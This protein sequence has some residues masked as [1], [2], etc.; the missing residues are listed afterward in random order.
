MSQA[1]AA[2]PQSPVQELKAPA[3]LMRADLVPG[4][5][6]DY[7]DADGQIRTG[8]VVS[9]TNEC[10]TLDTGMPLVVVH[11]PVTGVLHPLQRTHS[12]PLNW[13]LVVD[14]NGGDG[15]AWTVIGPNDKSTASLAF[16][17]DNERTSDEKGIRI[18]KS[19]L[20][21]LDKL[22]TMLTD[23]DLW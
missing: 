15:L 16:A 5:W 11:V 10:I 14:S 20:S 3:Q 21:A 6:T 22:A 1:A 4:S 18:P 12:L 7:H 17:L 8:R 9:A 19:V 23:A 2:A 13:R